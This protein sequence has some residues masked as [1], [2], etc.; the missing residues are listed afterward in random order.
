M[1]VPGF[2]PLGAMVVVYGAV[3]EEVPEYVSVMVT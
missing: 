2:V 3:K 1:T